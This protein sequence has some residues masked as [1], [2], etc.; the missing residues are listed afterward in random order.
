MSHWIM[1]EICNSISTIHCWKKFDFINYVTFDRLT[2]ID[3][4]EIHNHICFDSASLA[5]EG[6]VYNYMCYIIILPYVNRLHSLN[7]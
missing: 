1:L 7:K 5:S 2:I 6:W 3:G 4:L